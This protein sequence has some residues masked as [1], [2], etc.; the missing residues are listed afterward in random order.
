MRDGGES[1]ASGEE[2]AS[3]GL[4]RE[5]PIGALRATLESPPR[6]L[7]VNTALG[8]M[9]GVEEAAALHGQ[10]LEA[11]A[12]D[13]QQLEALIDGL[14]RVGVVR[15]RELDLARVDGQTFRVRVT[16]CAGG[17]GEGTPM[18]EA[19]VE[20]V[21]GGQRADH[22]M[23]ARQAL[24]E[25][26]QRL[27]GV[28]YWVA[29]WPD[30][31]AGEGGAQLWWSPMLYEIFGWDPAQEP[32]SLEAFFS[33]VH[34]EDRE[35]VY[36]A[37]REAEHRGEYRIEHRI[38][39]PDGEVRWIRELGR[40]E[41]GPQ[42]EL[43]RMIGT[44]QEVTQ[45]RLLVA[46][47][48][49]RASHDPLTGLYNRR[50]LLEILSD[51]QARYERYRVPFSVILFDVDHFKRIND[52]Y[53]H[54]CGDRILRDLALR[55]QGVLR[56]TDELARWGGEEFMILAPHTE[57]DGA[58]QL[59]ERVRQVIAG[60]APE[61]IEV[62]ASLGVTGTAPGMTLQRLE[63]RADRAMYAAKRNGRDNVQVTEG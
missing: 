57:P 33:A 32:P 44:A 5:L 27:A 59:A 25:D 19:A 46:E 8:R 23:A 14:R 22:E 62:T 61:G 3:W 10:P 43:V 15:Q 38:Q 37:L 56:E 11:L 36:S 30:H 53:G 31:E 6:L 47:L 45:Q 16:A 52:R 28:G 60:S 50:K 55:V 7:E 58:A 12:A 17:D 20:D 34:P 24:L 26:A 2:P 49:R 1:R 54:P 40:V 9:L 51:H 29:Q 13:R 63:D 48:E 42:G 18:M 41:Y 39:R 21:A 35:A 4:L